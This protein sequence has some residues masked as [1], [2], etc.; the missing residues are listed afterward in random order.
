MLMLTSILFTVVQKTY[1][2]RTT[3]VREA[4]LKAVEALKKKQMRALKVS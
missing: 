3:L 4:V 1:K 2:I